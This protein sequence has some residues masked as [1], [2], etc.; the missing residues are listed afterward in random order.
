M[1]P[2]IWSDKPTLLFFMYIYWNLI[3]ITEF[4]LSSLDYKKNQYFW[5]NTRLSSFMCF[6]YHRLIFVNQIN[7]FFFLERSWNIAVDIAII[8]RQ[9]IWQLSISLNSKKVNL[10]IHNSHRKQN[11]GNETNTFQLILTMVIHVT[12]CSKFIVS[13]G[14]ANGAIII[15]KPLI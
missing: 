10:I 12:Y 6:I 1:K 3:C 9:L 14:L 5:R 15:A 11:F 7:N 2:S 4:N 8:I 13:L